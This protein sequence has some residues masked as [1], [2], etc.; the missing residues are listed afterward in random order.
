MVNFQFVLAVMFT[1]EVTM[2]ALSLTG[3]IVH[4]SSRVLDAQLLSQMS[5]YCD[6]C[7]RSIVEEIAEEADRA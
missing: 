3:E 4:P 1:N 6:R 5:D 7:F 2:A